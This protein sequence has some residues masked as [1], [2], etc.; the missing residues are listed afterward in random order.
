[1]TF[2]RGAAVSGDWLLPGPLDKPPLSIYLSALSMVCRCASRADED[3]GVLQLDPHL[4]EF[5]GPACRMRCLAIV[6]TALMM[7]LAGRLLSRA[8]WA[9]LIG[10]LA[11]TA[12]SPYLLA[13]RRRR[14][15]RYELAVLVGGLRCILRL[16]GRAAP[17]WFGAGAGLSGASSRRRSFGCAASLW[18]WW[19]AAAGRRDWLR[20][21]L[22]PMASLS[23]V[24]LILGWRAAGGE[25][26]R[27]R[28]RPTMRRACG[29]LIAS[30]C[31]C[32]APG[33]L[34]WALGLWLLGPPL[35]TGVLAGWRRLLCQPVV[36][37]GG[38]RA[39]ARWRFERAL[40]LYVIAFLGAHVA[41]AASMCTIAICC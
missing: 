10:G 35:V 21:A 14:F 16:K 26:F 8:G 24:L 5:A 23:A 22:P 37:A 31:G 11:L 33:R 4:G 19:R 18:S 29:W 30:V 27:C 28:R 25:H 15:D 12:V 39:M 1:M 36:A 2:A 6:L 32:G 7:R 9:A 34:A 13:Y 17:A 40:L 38:R 3:G 41:L 20:L